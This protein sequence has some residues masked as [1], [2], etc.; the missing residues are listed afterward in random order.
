MPIDTQAS[1]IISVANNNKTGA[2]QICDK[3]GQDFE[4]MLRIEKFQENSF[5]R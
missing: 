4:L 5:D 1:Q 3:F 2:C